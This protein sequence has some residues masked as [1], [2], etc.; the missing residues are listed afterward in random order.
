[1]KISLFNQFGSLN[2]VEVFDAF[3]I[4][5]KRLGHEVV[6]HDMTADVYVIWSCLWSGR[7]AQ[8]KS[9]WEYAQQ[10]N[11]TVI[12]LEVGLLKR[13][14]TWRI[15]I[16]GYTLPKTYTK[17]SNILNVSMKPWRNNGSHILL[18]GQ[19]PS[20]HLWSNM[21]TVEEW[22][23]S[24]MNKIKTFSDRPIIFRPHP[25]DHT[26]FNVPALVPQKLAGTY[27]DYDFDSAL[28]NA[29]MVINPSSTP[30][31]LSIISGVPVIV[32]PL[33]LAYPMSTDIKDIENPYRPDREEWFE[34]VCN[35]EWTIDELKKIELEYLL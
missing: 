26:R 19:N 29:W 5:V 7:M 16:N 3:T 27:D 22:V 34:Q 23:I 25:R 12:I 35:T 17:R 8:N 15:G 2:S 6:Y 9:I 33:S 21:P 31:P 11:I 18:C 13:G 4:G 28:D 10:H 24:T 30:G 20:S 14:I 32:S 1:M